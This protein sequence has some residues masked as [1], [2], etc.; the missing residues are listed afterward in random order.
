MAFYGV[1]LDIKVKEL[2]MNFKMHLQRAGGNGLR[3]LARIFKRFDFNGNGKLDIMEF[4]E[5]LGQFG[6]F[7]SKV[8]LQALIKFYDADGDG[9]VTYNEF[10]NGLKDP[11]TERQQALVDKAFGLMDKDGSG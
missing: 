8:E 3:S 7:P 2:N 6:L 4:E 11:L 9:N 10:I 1:G 5:A